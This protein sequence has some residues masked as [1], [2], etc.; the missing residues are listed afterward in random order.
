MHKN[1]HV[2]Y[3]S[4]LSTKITT[5]PD[6]SLYSIDR[7][8]FKLKSRR[9]T[10]TL[11]HERALESIRHVKRNEILRS[12]DENEFVKFHNKLTEQLR[13]NDQLPEFIPAFYCF[14]NTITAHK[15]I[16]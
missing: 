8:Y 6:T 1:T 12:N 16:T 15:C 10:Q 7:Y 9:K 11:R 13:R 14:Q 5:I 4:A 2:A 3:G